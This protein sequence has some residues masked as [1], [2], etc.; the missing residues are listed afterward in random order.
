[1][2]KRQSVLT[3]LSHAGL[4]TTTDDQHRLKSNVLPAENIAGQQNLDNHT[5]KRSYQQP[6]IA[7]DQHR[8]KSNVLP[9]EN[10]IGQQNLDRYI[11][12]RSYE[13]SPILNAMYNSDQQMK[14][15]V[16]LGQK[17]RTSSGQGL[18]AHNLCIQA[19]SRWLLVF[20]MN[21]TI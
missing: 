7:D 12:K 10:T 11:Q 20:T 21:R 17:S 15:I 2:R 3:R 5:R 18:R 4:K 13:Q 14:Q 19:N 1:M 6:P 8:L 9:E 16:Q